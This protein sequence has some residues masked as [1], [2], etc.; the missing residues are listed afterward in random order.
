MQIRLTERL[1]RRLLHIL[2]C[3]VGYWLQQFIAEAYLELYVLIVTDK[4]DLHAYV[5]NLN[6]VLKRLKNNVDAKELAGLVGAKI[7]ALQ[8]PRAKRLLA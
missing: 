5:F 8:V 2:D 3:A 7:V 6:D 4:I 1:S